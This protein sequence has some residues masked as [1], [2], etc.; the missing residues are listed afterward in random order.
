MVVG[1]AESFAVAGWCFEPELASGSCF[2]NAAF[3]QEAAC[4]A[5][6]IQAALSK[7]IAENP[8]QISAGPEGVGIQQFLAC[9]W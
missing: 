1:A 5:A 8:P 2:R 4:D 7:T 6:R 3:V 9:K